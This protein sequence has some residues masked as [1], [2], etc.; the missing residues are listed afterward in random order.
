MYTWNVVQGLAIV[1][2]Q[3]IVGEFLRNGMRSTEVSNVP[4]AL[5]V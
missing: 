4:G 2:S 5:H 3:K 1:C